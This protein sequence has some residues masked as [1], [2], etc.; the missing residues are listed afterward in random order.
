MNKNTVNAWPA[1]QFFVEM[2]TRDIELKD[3]ILDLLDNCLDGAMR[4]EENKGINTNSESIYKNY[5]ANITLNENEF[6]IEDNCGGISKELAMNYAFRLGRPNDRK[7]E[8]MP[9]IGIYGIGMKRAMFKLGYSSE[10]FTKTEDE[11]FVVRITPEWLGDDKNWDLTLEDEH[12]NLD[13][14]GTKIIV[15]SLRDNVSRLLGDTV[16]FQ[17]DLRKSISHHYSII[18][19]KGFK[20]SINNIPVKPAITS[21]LFDESSL[22]KADG[23]FPYVYENNVDGVDI[24]M[25]LGFYR[26]LSSESEDT[27]NIHGRNTTEQAG[28]TIICNDRVVLYADKTRTTGWGEASVPSY[29]TQFISI[30]GIVRFTSSDANKLP[31]TTTK[32]GVDGN[33]EIYLSAKDFMREAL[34]IF[35]S[36]TNKWK[37]NSENKI[38]IQESS[39]QALNAT[40]REFITMIP[41][42]KWTKVTRSFGGKVFKPNLPKPKETDPTRQVKF[43]KKLAEIKLVSEYIFDNDSVPPGDV[44]KKCFELI[45]EKAINE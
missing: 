44:G 39:K 13:T 17:S 15:R 12:S 14:P 9:T 5:H 20:V 35:T 21:L 19:E 28:W 34:K 23:I 32:R 43:N 7:T 18:I 2:L 6:I 24:Q 10:V 37:E 1:K 8:N 11:E 42:N 25:V 30:A 33:S 29:H 22:H 27:D 36:F 26:P 45:L 40:S 4:L 3:A 41:E 16:L 31:I 38:A